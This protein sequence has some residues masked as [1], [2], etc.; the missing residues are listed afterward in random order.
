MYLISLPNAAFNKI[1]FFNKYFDENVVLIF[2]KNNKDE[3][4]S[5]NL[6]I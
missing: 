6:L 3:D 2:V 1:S 5:R 4:N